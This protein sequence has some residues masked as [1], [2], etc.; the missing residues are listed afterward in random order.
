VDLG[1]NLP[2]DP[3]PGD[4]VDRWSRSLSGG[5]RWA[6]A[7]M[8]ENGRTLARTRVPNRETLFPPALAAEFTKAALPVGE[9][10][11][12]EQDVQILSAIGP[13]DPLADVAFTAV[14]DP[15]G[16]SGIGAREAL[17]RRNRAKQFVSLRLWAGPGSHG[18]HPIFRRAFLADLS[19]APSPVSW[20]V[21]FER[22]AA[23]HGEGAWHHH[24]LLARSGNVMAGAGYLAQLLDRSDAQR[25]LAELECITSAPRR[26]D[27]ERGGADF[28]AE[29]GAA[30]G[31]DAIQ[32]LGE[33][34]RHVIVVVA[35]L[36]LSRNH[37]GGAEHEEFQRAAHALERLTD[38]RLNPT[39]TQ[40]LFAFATEL[41]TRQQFLDELV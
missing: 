27:A 11:E 20:D 36:W 3:D 41:R 28:D 15:P 1:H 22:L 37:R 5:H 23:A 6:Y 26:R 40:A 16:A 14:L 10:R 31:G 29:L 25:W 33:R 32:A 24:Y 4:V 38:T 9:T 35:A 18:L 2:R 30:S 12:L 13:R 21:V 19:R 17:I 34:E 39:L 8:Y 7:R